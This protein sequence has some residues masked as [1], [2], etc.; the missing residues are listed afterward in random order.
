MIGKDGYYHHSSGIGGAFTLNRHKF[1]YARVILLTSLFWVLVDVF[2]IYYLTADCSVTRVRE[3]C[4]PHLQFGQPAKFLG[5]EPDVAPKEPPP[6]D[7]NEDETMRRRNQRLREIH[8]RRSTQSPT[9]TLAPKD[10]NFL[11]K[12]KEWFRED[13]SHEPTNPPDWPGENGRAVVVPDSLKDAVQQRFKEN[14]FNIVA[15]DLVA[16]NRSVPDQ[17]SSACRNREYPVDLPTTSI[18]IVYHNEGNSTLLRGLVSIIRKSPNQYLKEII[19]V[20]DASE[21][22][23]YLHSPLDA[24]VKTLPVRVRIFRNEQRLG[25]MR[26][27]LVGA[28]AA[29]GDTLTFLDAHIEATDGWLTPLLNEIKKN[30]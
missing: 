20:D 6:K 3:P 22:R 27:R 26:S 23:E 16:L 30:R 8:R 10:N 1:Q 7:D 21:G 9:A 29:T 18:I 19:L 15:S 2:L 4:D 14:Q 5:D 13:N 12:L 28:D 25:L 11:N 17:R 24:F